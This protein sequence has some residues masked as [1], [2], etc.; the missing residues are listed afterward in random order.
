MIAADVFKGRPWVVA[1]L[2]AVL[3]AGCT[4]RPTRPPPQPA[5]Q[6]ETQATTVTKLTV[7]TQATTVTELPVE[8]GA[9][10]T[11]TFEAE[12]TGPDPVL[13]LLDR[14]GREVAIAQGTRLVYRAPA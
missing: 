6:H 11:V 14:P 3:A 5:P 12:G 2:V 10:E 13:H 7:E 1:A 4:G 9:H 8:L